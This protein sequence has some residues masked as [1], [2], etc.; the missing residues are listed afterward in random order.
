[1]LVAYPTAVL[2]HGLWNGL[3]VFTSLIAIANMTNSGLEKYAVIIS[4]TSV[5]LL[6]S[7]GLL[8]FLLLI[9]GNW[10]LRRS[11]RP[12]VALITSPFQP[13]TRAAVFEVPAASGQPGAPVALT[14]PM[15]LEDNPAGES[16]AGQT[17]TSPMQVT[18][19]HVALEGE[20]HNIKFEE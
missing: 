13:G 12:A 20:E 10:L 16:L 5:V 11:S 18:S 15:K 17:A 14:D 7:L 9:G 8:M 3:A 2:L 1:M 4:S 19:D 6:I